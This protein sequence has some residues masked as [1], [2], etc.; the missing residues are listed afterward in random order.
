MH[1]CTRTRLLVPSPT[2][3]LTPLSHAYTPSLVPLPPSTTHN[4]PDPPKQPYL[5][6]VYSLLSCVY[7]RNKETEALCASINQGGA[8]VIGMCRKRE[9]RDAD[10][11]THTHTPDTGRPR[12]QQRRRQADL[13]IRVR[14]IYLYLSMYQC[15]YL[16]L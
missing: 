10:T 12:S 11:G 8:A 5:S 4:S 13:L 2:Q 14:H 7:S 1:G 16:Y 9:R 3:Q 6:R 15:L